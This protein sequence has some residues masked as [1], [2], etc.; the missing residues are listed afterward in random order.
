MVN[1]FLT[2]AQASGQIA[3]LEREHFGRWK[4]ASRVGSITFQRKMR[5][6]FPNGSR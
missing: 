6:T 4:H 2:S 5:K 3:Q 1:A